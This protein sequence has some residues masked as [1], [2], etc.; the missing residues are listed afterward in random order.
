MGVQ[1]AQNVYAGRGNDPGYLDAQR[2][3]LGHRC[4]I[5]PVRLEGLEMD[6]QAPQLDRMPEVRRAAAGT[7]SGRRG[8]QAGKLDEI[9]KGSGG[10][11]R[12]RFHVDALWWDGR[13][14]HALIARAGLEMRRHAGWIGRLPA[15]VLKTQPKG[16]FDSLAGRLDTR[17]SVSPGA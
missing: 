1:D 5:G 8:P 2:L 12:T 13:H 10:T 7:G 14:V 6:L 4:Q 3:S 16:N 15:L 17:R 9:A 11:D